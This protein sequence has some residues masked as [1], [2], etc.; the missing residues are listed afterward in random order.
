MH[1]KNLK[2]NKYHSNNMIIKRKLYTKYD[3]TDNLKRMKDSD[4]LAEKPKQAPGYGSVAAGAL[5]GAALGGTVGLV[6]GALSKAKPNT[7]WLGRAAKGGK[8]GAILGGLAVG[9]LALHNRNKQS[10]ENEW[11]NNRLQYAQRHARRREKKDWKTNM[12]QRD[13]YSY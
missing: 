6:G 2:N 1:T 9:G 5:G 10:K 13:G 11:Y 8:T 7:T 4:I 3:D 12:T